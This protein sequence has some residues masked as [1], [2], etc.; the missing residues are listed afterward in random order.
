M[1]TVLIL[2]VILGAVS[3][4]IWLGLK[5]NP[6]SFPAFPQATPEVKTFALPAGLPAPV[7]RF[8]RKVYGERLP[9]IETVVMS[10]R[11]TLRPFGSL[12]LPGRF[13]FTHD[14]G[15]G[16]RHYIE[17]NWFGLP[18]LKV[19]ERYV[20]GSSYFELP[21]GVSQGPNLNQAANLGMWAELSWT[22]SVF[23]TAPGVRWEAL[24][25][26]TAILVV[27]FE[28]SEERFVVR[29]DPQS[30]LLRY[31]EVMRYKNENSTAKSLWITEAL[32]YGVLDG[33][34]TAVQGSATWLED[35][36]P[37]AVFTLE[38]MR[39]NVDIREYLR[40]RGQ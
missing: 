30:D 38:E 17:A 7:E 16:Y 21:F 31:M 8:Y 12:T 37:W 15:R 18:V 25:D 29:F 14:V 5:I 26:A 10:G 1:K 32:S 20:D 36:S 22:P 2:L 34:P 28:Q 3:A 9:V 13:R 23:L 35:G 6:A 39:F 40:A 11:A 24:D 19:N 4:L 27:P 33:A